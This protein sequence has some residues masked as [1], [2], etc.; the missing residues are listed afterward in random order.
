MPVDF[1]DVVDAADVR[2]GHLTRHPHLGVQLREAC[3]ILVHAGRKELQRDRLTQLEGA[4]DLSHAAAA[5]ASDDPVPGSEDV[6][7]LESS[8]IDPARRGQPAAAG[9]ATAR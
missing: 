1:V 3:G 4:K 9:R 8:V 5:E 7:W 2:M 6:A